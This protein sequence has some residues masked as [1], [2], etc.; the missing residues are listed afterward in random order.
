MSTVHYPAHESLQEY[1]ARRRMP[2]AAAYPSWHDRSYPAI[3]VERT[4]SETGCRATVELPACDPGLG[5]HLRDL[6]RAATS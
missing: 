2:V 6:P 1:A 5:L 4:D 3:A